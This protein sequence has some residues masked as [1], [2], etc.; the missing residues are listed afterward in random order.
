MNKKF[1]FYIV[2]ISLLL[3]C[4]KE[5]EKLIRIDPPIPNRTFLTP[6]IFWK[7][8]STPLRFPESSAV[9]DL[10]YGYNRAKICWYTIDPIL[11]TINPLLPA[12]LSKTDLSNDYVRLI[13]ET[14]VLQNKDIPSGMPTR[15]TALNIDFYPSKIG[16]YNFNLE[17]NNFSSGIDENANLIHPESRW[18][19]ITSVINFIDHDINYIVFWMMDP[20][21]DNENISGDLFINIGSFSE[22]ILKDNFHQNESSISP[23]SNNN[24]TCCWGLY[25]ITNQWT[26]QFSNVNY[27]DIG[28]DGLNNSQERTF[29][30]NYLTTANQICSPEAYNTIIE[31]PCN[32]DYHYFRGSDY[33]YLAVSIADRYSGFNGF[34]GNSTANFPNIESYPTTNSSFPDK[35]DIN[36]NENINSG[37]SYYEYHITVNNNLFV[38]ESNYIDSIQRSHIHTIDNHVHQIDW[39]HFKIPIQ[40]YTSAYG[41][42]QPL[43]EF[44]M[45][46]VYL[47]NFTEPVTLR[48]AEFYITE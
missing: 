2:F 29:F 22:E 30:N 41:S 39:Y 42:I 27:Q 4:K 14:E 15:L 11:Q 34:E 38:S 24:D 45:I 6:S 48:L 32:D 36:N 35:E 17:P 8:S 13:W 23:I 3:C 16:P 9:N 28:L 47:T 31:D 21:I 26:N 19:G 1:L 20:F 5:N 33:D 40:S 43:S 18:G 25:G 44:K 12:H 46:R 10:A 37:S 7:L